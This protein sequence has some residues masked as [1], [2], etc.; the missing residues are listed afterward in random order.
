MGLIAQIK[1][2]LERY[3]RSDACRVLN[4]RMMSLVLKKFQNLNHLVNE[5]S[6]I[7]AFSLAS[8]LKSDKDTKV[9][10][11]SEAKTKII[12]SEE[13]PPIPPSL[14]F[15]G[16]DDHRAIFE[17]QRINNSFKYGCVNVGIYLF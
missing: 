15:P 4:L 5:L 7:R 9:S 1:I 10:G 8:S 3:K 14:G 6:G 16:N 12:I 2:Q 11:P 17:I 13:Q